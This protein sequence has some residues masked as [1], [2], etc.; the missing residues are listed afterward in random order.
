M[1]RQRVV[2]GPPLRTGDRLAHRV[3]GLGDDA[4]LWWASTD[5]PGTSPLTMDAAAVALMP[6]ARR[7]GVDL[8][9]AGQ[10]ARSRLAAIEELQDV[11]SAWPADK[12]ERTRITA[13]EVHDDVPVTGRRGL[14][15]FSGGLDAV[16]SL[17]AHRTGALGHRS[18][19]SLRAMFIRRIELNMPRDRD[20]E[21]AVA[22][23][24]AIADEVGAPLVTVETNWRTAF[25]PNYPMHHMLGIAGA[26]RAMVQPGER[27]LV[28]S[29][30]PYGSEVIP[31]GANALTDR[32]LGQNAHPCEPTGY[33]VDRIQ[34]CRAVAHLASVRE[35]LRVCWQREAPG[36]NC[37][38]CE[39]CVRSKLSFLAAG[40]GEIP[41]LGA[42]SL[43]QVAAISL[44]TSIARLHLA[45]LLDYESELGP[46]IAGAVRERLGAS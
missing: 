37:G 41:A 30:A 39:K 14:L 20:I 10:V 34:K 42:L 44:N 32:L 21:R 29:G 12:H 25:S 4:T 24:R 27:V 40:V 36:R 46:R 1:T 35:G 16:Y 6:K 33:G 31:H 45:R 17:V 26:L 8:H 2:V 13:D 22:S 9:L 5:L 11:W 28:S 7:R 43:E 18:V 15:A 3:D 23:A 38:S 19:P